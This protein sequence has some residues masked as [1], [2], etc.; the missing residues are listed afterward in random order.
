MITASVQSFEP[1]A[2]IIGVDIIGAIDN[3]SIDII[4]VYRIINIQELL[5]VTITL[6]RVR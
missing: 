5:T 4:I 6:D 3:N 2:E 1:R